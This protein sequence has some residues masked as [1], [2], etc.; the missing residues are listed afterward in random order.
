M[1]NSSKKKSG[2]RHVAVPRDPISREY[3]TVVR[4]M[5]KA[6]S[7]VATVH[8]VF[9]LLTTVSTNASGY[10]PVQQYDSTSVTGTSDW[11]LANRYTEYRIKSIRVRWFP[12]V[13]E[14]QC[15]TTTYTVIPA[16]GPIVGATYANS[17]GYGS[18]AL[19][20]NGS[21]VQFFRTCSIVDKTVDSKGYPDAQLW[22]PANANVAADSRFGM[23]LSDLG[24]GPTSAVSTI[25]YRVFVQYLVELRLP[26]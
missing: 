13:T 6:Q 18:A 12:L 11:S 16:P 25:Y 8:R 5:E 17:Y 24:T 19:R 1:S 7:R 22:T 20:A 14:V 4:S 15:A 9:S 2:K 3:G 23:E 10:I 26:Q 21:E